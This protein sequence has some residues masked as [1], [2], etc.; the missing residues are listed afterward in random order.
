MKIPFIIA[1]RGGDLAPEN[2]MPSFEAASAMGAQMVEFDV[3]LSADNRLV[4][5]HDET[6][7]R[8]TN[9]RGNI[10]DFS[11]ADIRLMDAGSWYSGAFVYTQIPTL[12]EV[13]EYCSRK[14]LLMNLEIKASDDHQQNLKITQHV[15]AR[16]KGDEALQSQILLSCFDNQCLFAAR[17]YLPDIAMG[18][19]LDIHDWKNE[20]VRAKDK[21]KEVDQLECLSVHINHWSDQTDQMILTERHVEQIKELTK[22][23]HLL[24]YTVNDFNRASELRDWGVDAV[25]SDDLDLMERF[26]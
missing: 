10:K 23:K 6:V 13:L 18:Y 2:T 14:N 20:W 25:F 9:M 22:A 26:R 7:D 15:V 8:T 12:D 19:L 21:L 11:L 24:S 17:Q 3:Q 16:L 1:H 4:V 5:I